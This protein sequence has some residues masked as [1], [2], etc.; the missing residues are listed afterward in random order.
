MSTLYVVATPIGNLEDLSQRALR[1]LAEVSAVAAEDTRL[2]G[3]LLSRHG[4]RKPLVSYRAPVERRGLPRVLAALAAGDVALVSDA[5]TPAVSDP[6]Q[7]LVAASWR[8]GHTVVPLP[9]PSAVTT[10]LSAAGFPGTGFS[11][12]GYLPRKPGELRRF[13]ASL[14]ETRQPTVAF[15]SPHR[16][17]KSL[18]V[19]AETLPERPLLL[20]RELTKLHEELRRGTAARVLEELGGR[21]RGEFTVVISGSES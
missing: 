9:G 18:T 16:V 7:Q 12:V 8:D 21:A 5:G 6:G 10:A 2:T 13:F 1:I 17:L 19:L 15:E 14:A 20:A 4:L 11:F 3:R